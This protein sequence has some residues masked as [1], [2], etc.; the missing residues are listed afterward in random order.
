[1]SKKVTITYFWR[2]KLTFLAYTTVNQITKGVDYY[3]NKEE[4]SHLK[5]FRQLL[6]GLSVYVTATQIIEGVA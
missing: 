1:M 4:A 6:K 3:V 5:V 2:Q